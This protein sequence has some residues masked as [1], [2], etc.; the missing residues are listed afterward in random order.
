MSTHPETL[1]SLWAHC[2]ASNRLVPMPPQWQTLYGML[3][4]RL[5]KP[6]GGW[7]PP[8]PLILAAWHDSM[9]I[10]KQLRFKEHLEWAEKQGQTVEVGTYLRSLSEA[11]WCHFGEF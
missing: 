11:Q 3:R 5:Q 9:P 4:N 7:E 1:E 10:A 8:L 2:T 6:S